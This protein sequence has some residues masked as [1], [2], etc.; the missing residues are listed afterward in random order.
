MVPQ[1]NIKIPYE[2]QKCPILSK[3][4]FFPSKDQDCKYLYLTFFFSLLAVRDKFDDYVSSVFIQV[5]SK[6]VEQ[7]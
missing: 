3:G 7:D 2:H 5:T 6:S 1:V 4:F